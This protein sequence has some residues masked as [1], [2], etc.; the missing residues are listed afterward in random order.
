MAPPPRPVDY[1]A[2]NGPHAQIG[3]CRAMATLAPTAGDLLRDWRRRRRFSQMDLAGD[4]EISTRHLSF[5]E[6]GRS[7]ASR[8]VLHRL[9]ERLAMPLRARNQLLA[10]AGFAAGYPERPIEAPT[11]DCARRAVE[12]VLKGHEPFPALAVDRHW[13]LVMM[14]DAVAPLLAGVGAALLAPPVNVLRLSLH[15]QG[16]APR[17]DNLGEWRAHLFERLGRQIDETGDATLMALLEELHGYPSRA[18]TRP[19]TDLAGVAVPLRL[20]V[21]GDGEPLSLISTTTVF[22][23]PLDVTLAE[24]AI[25]CFFPADER[26]RATLLARAG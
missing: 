5:V 7:N 14:N 10:A 19:P 20:R 24:I 2:G 3:Y 13:Q 11:L 8:D 26:T 18:G 23:T 15:P 16:L 9:A 25:E 4:A 12:L 21:E 1:L 22:G 6:T 17:I